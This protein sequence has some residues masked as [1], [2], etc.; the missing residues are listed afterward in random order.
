M[1]LNSGTGFTAC[2]PAFQRDQ[3]TGRP[4]AGPGRIGRPTSLREK[5]RNFRHTTLA[6]E[7][8]SME[9]WR[10][11]NLRHKR[12]SR[13]C[14]QSEC[15]SRKLAMPRTRGH[16]LRHGCQATLLHLRS[17]AGLHFASAVERSFPG[18]GRTDA[19]SLASRTD[20]H[21]PYNLFLLSPFSHQP[22]VRILDLWSFRFTSHGNASNRGAA[23]M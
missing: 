14:V 20:S 22:V 10:R 17:A 9:C 13:V 16:A 21:G 12:A 1:V 4:L 5:R 6:S 19:Y 11:A 23:G 7:I 15:A 8:R 18:V 3:P 2:G